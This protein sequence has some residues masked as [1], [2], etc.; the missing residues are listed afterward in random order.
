MFAPKVRAKG[1]SLAA[2]VAPD[3]PEWVRGDAGR[4][5][6]VLVNLIGNAVKF[7]EE[8]GV[9]VTVSLTGATD[10]GCTLRFE[11]ADT[12]MGISQSARQRLFQPFTQ[13]DGSMARKYGGTGLGLAISRRLVELMGGEIG[14][15]SEEGAGACFWFTMQCRHASAD[16]AALRRRDDG[17]GRFTD[18]GHR[19]GDRRT[20]PPC[21]GQPDQSAAGY[22]ATATAGLRRPCRKR[23][24]AGRGNP[25]P[26]TRRVRPGADGLPDA[27]D[28]W[29][30]CHARDPPRRVRRPAHP[31]HR[32]DGQR[33]ARRP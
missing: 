15:V 33:H 23:W 28:G 1:L 20:D 19:R 8:G 31:H 13:A 17:R 24:P 26:T 18:P 7:T 5:H 32:H 3:V 16:P 30:R 29:L 9:E 10:A 2:A 11:V 22:P 27:G 12:G 6:Q 14:V 4:L 21:R 25:G